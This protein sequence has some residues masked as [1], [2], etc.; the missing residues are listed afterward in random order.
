MSGNMKLDGGNPSTVNKNPKVIKA[1]QN[2]IGKIDVLVCGSCFNVFHFV[3]EFQLHK[4]QEDCVSNP[5][6]KQ[7]SPS[8]TKPQVWAFLLW[9]SSILNEN[10]RFGEDRQADEL[11]SWHLYQS[12]CKLEE[13]I[14]DSWIAAGRAI[15]GFASIANAKI[16]EVRSVPEK[17]RVTATRPES[18]ERKDSPRSQPADRNALQSKV[19][20]QK[21][22]PRSTSLDHENAAKD[23]S[24]RKETVFEAKDKDGSSGRQ[25]KDSSHAMRSKSSAVS[26]EDNYDS[27]VSPSSTGSQGDRAFHRGSGDSLMPDIDIKE[28]QMSEEEEEE[29]EME[30]G[31]DNSKTRSKEPA[32]RGVRTNS[33]K[34]VRKSIKDTKALDGNPA[35]AGEEEYVVEKILAKRYNPKKKCFEYLLKWEG[36][37]HE[38][39]TWEPVEN[40]Q[41]C[42]NLVEAFER[43]LAKQK[44]M[45]QPRPAAG[46]PIQP[47]QRPAHQPQ[48]PAQPSLR[49]S[50]VTS[51][52][53]AP[54]QPS[55][56]PPPLAVR[57][58]SE[59]PP[60]GPH[61][62]EESGPT[63][64]AP[65]RHP[66]LG[67][68]AHGGWAQRR[69]I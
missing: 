68:G 64:G 23:S 31:G 67:A 60:A 41:A 19:A 37:P 3:E 48:G 59:P 44:M 16:Q 27:N 7:P 43:N 29:D 32:A 34:V 52:A 25:S 21:I 10:K 22:A 8:E 57:L 62:A 39:N 28:E 17:G 12:W 66:R 49:V 46:T 65:R 26:S 53:R 9:K 38:Q 6:F 4:L 54:Q 56:P 42:E 11:G 63:T 30:A 51:L 18:Q 47:P 36:Y 55:R 50:G 40:M 35:A 20:V 58:T 69:R 13:K 24:V 33:N 14:R 2:E 45:Q 15:Q 5:D 1:A 61:L